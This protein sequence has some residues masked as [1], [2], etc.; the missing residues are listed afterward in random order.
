MPHWTPMGAA[1]APFSNQIVW[2][3]EKTAVAIIFMPPR[4]HQ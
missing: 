2:F 4:G 3:P 1:I